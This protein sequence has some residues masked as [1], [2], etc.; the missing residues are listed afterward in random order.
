M[1]MQMRVDEMIDAVGEYDPEAAKR[2]EAAL[3]ALA[4]VMAADIARHYEIEAS[5][6]AH[7]GVGFA[8]LCAAFNPAK[9]GQ[10]FPSDLWDCMDDGGREEWAEDLK[11]L[12]AAEAERIKIG[13]DE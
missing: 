2:Y 8:G 3:V 12:E 1:S 6:A 5:P 4:D 13:G 7:E 11:R 10:P 9:P